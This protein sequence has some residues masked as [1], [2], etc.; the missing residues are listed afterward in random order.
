M[1]IELPKRLDI[2]SKRRGYQLAYIEDGVLKINSYMSFRKVMIEITY[3][4]KGKN[5]CYYCGKTFPE[6]KITVDHFIPLDFGGPTISENLVPVC[7]ACNHK[8]GNMTFEQ[9]Q[10]YLELAKTGKAKKKK[11]LKELWKEQEKTRKSKKYLIPED[12]IEEK[13]VNDIILKDDREVRDSKKYDYYEQYYY[14]YGMIKKPIVVDRNNYLLDG[15][16]SLK[17]AKN[18]RLDTIP[19]IVLENV[20]VIHK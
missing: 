19:T 9:Y 3:M 2:K 7:N 13:P 16:L 11:F 12:W 17:V 8:K 5:R 15:Y 6:E 1:N 18:N 4:L 10:N 20:E 14:E